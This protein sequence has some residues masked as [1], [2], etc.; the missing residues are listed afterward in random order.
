MSD[1]PS[2]KNFKDVYQEKAIWLPKQSLRRKKDGK[3]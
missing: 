2:Q 3:K 1:N